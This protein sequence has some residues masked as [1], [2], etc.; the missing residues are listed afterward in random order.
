MLGKPQ[1]YFGVMLRGS[2]LTPL[3]L[4][5]A[6]PAVLSRF[7]SLMLMARREEECFWDIPYELARTLLLVLLPMAHTQAF[8]CFDFQKWH[9]LFLFKE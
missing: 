9:V 6:F 7:F 1:L 4:Y 3:E 8:C 5:L 2:V